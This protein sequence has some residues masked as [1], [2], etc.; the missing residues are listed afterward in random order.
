MIKKLICY[1]KQPAYIHNPISANLFSSMTLIG[2]SVT[3]YLIFIIC[4]TVLIFLPLKLLNLVTDHKILNHPLTFKI[5]VLVPFYEEL[6]FRLPLRFSIKN[7]FISIGTFVF[8]LL[9]KY[10]NIYLSL[11]V[12]FL[13]ASFP[14]FKIIQG[15]IINKI[16]NSFVHYY[17]IHFY[18]FSIT[19]G[20][21]H[22][23]G[24]NELNFKQFL[25]SPL[26]VINQI[27]M[28]LLLG[29]LRINYK[30][31]FIY[32]FITHGLINLIFLVI[33]NVF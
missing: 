13:I 11:S 22:L 23:S 30:H 29:Y 2:K 18:I 17:K 31:G 10:F 25:I 5:L 27:F 28:G 26:L 7:I 20:L 15:N 6:I 33:K 4:T 3:I 32:C 12:G 24:F 16:Q 8:L 1:L 14:F 9:N 19:F 21:V